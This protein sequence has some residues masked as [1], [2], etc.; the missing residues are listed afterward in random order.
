MSRE[1]RCWSIPWAAGLAG[2]TITWPCGRALKTG[3]KIFCADCQRKIDTNP[4][5]IFDCKVEACREIALDLPKITDYLCEECQEHFDQ[6]LAYLDLYEFSYKVEPLLVRGLDYYTKTTFE[7]VSTGLGAQDAILGGGRYDDMMKDFGGPDIC[8]IGFALGMER[9]LQ[10]VPDEDSVREICV[11][12]LDGRCR[13]TRGRADSA[14]P[15]APGRG[16]FYRI[17]IP[18]IGQSDGPRK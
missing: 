9:L 3:I 4:L 13:Q 2:R 5:R 10:L 8:G 18:G 15:A 6:F 11:L 17:Q 16:V 12:G 14:I 1:R 7:F